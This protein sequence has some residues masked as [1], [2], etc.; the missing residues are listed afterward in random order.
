MSNTVLGHVTGA[1]LE[2]ICATL[3]MRPTQLLPLL[4]VPHS[5]TGPNL[6]RSLSLPY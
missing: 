2:T 4:V 6:G 5:K 1:E 3:T